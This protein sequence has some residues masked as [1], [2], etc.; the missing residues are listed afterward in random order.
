MNTAAEFTEHH[1]VANGATEVLTIAFG[2]E[3]LPARSAIGV[4]RCGSRSSVDTFAFDPGV[5]GPARI[6]YSFAGSQ[7]LQ[8]L[9]YSSSPTSGPVYPQVRGC[10]DSLLLTKLDVN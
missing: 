10:W 3:R 4:S 2:K 5:N 6:P 9:E 7:C 1:L 8:E